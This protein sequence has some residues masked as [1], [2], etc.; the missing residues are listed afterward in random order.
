MVASQSVYV[1]LKAVMFHC[2][3]VIVR[4]CVRGAC[5]TCVGGWVGGKEDETN[6]TW[7]AASYEVGLMWHARNQSSNLK[8]P[9]DGAAR[10]QGG[11]GHLRTPGPPPPSR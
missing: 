8:G 3:I 1:K 6:P 4:A 2:V 5:V 11:G 10:S 9:E 7:W